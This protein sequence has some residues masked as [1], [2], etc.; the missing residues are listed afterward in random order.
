MK[1]FIIH[2]LNKNL[3]LKEKISIGE[4]FKYKIKSSKFYIKEIIIL[5]PYI[6]DQLILTN[7]NKRYKKILEYYISI[8][9]DESDDAEGNFMIA[10]DEVARLR[11]ILIRKYN[12]IVSKKVEEKMLKKLKILENEMRSKVID[13]KIIKE[14]ENAIREELSVNKGR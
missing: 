3:K 11:N 8:L 6:I 12:L 10:L 2:D 5:D 1:N 4:G 14:Q 13:I 9:Q 7:F